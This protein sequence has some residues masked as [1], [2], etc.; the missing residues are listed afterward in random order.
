VP[1]SDLAMATDL[2]GYRVVG[3]KAFS[4][5]AVE[6]VDFSGAPSW[7]RAAISLAPP[8]AQPIVLQGL[9]KLPDTSVPSLNLEIAWARNFPP[10][11]LAIR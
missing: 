6:F 9:V 2:R 1:P 4:G 3:D 10:L 5:C 8:R 11:Q 7:P